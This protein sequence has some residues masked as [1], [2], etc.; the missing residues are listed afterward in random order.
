MTL[1]EYQAL[2]QRTV[3]PDQGATLRMAVAGLGI[4]G[5]A[6]EAAEMVKKHIGHGHPMDCGKLA[7][8]LGDVLW[9]VAELAAIVGVS[10]DEVAA[11]NIDKLRQRYPDGFSSERSINRPTGNGG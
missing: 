5:E 7:K 6:G 3:N 2:A 11:A 9:Y 8:E 10:L 1:N 4:A